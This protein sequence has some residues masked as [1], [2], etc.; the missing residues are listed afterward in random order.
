MKS[1]RYLSAALILLIL[2]TLGCGRE[3]EPE[4]EPKIDIPVRLAPVEVRTMSKPV[5]TYGRIASKR[6]IK[7]SFKTGGIIDEIL[8]DE[9][10]T[11]SRGQILARLD[12]AEIQA[13]VRQARSNFE[14]AERDAKRLQS[15]FDQEAAT[16]AQVQ[17]VET[18]LQ[19]ARAR[20]RAAEF[21]LQHSVI[22]A[23][24]R[25]RILRR[26]AEEDEVAAAGIPIFV[27]AS[28]ASDWVVRVGVSDADLVRLQL[29]DPAV[30]TFDAYPGEEFSARVAEIVE[31]ADP[32]TG[33]YEVELKIDSADKILV[34]GFVAE[35]EISPLRTR[36]FFVIP[37]DALTEAE[38]R[39]GRVFTVDRASLTARELTISIAF[40]FEDK[41]AV[42]EGLDGI[43]E[44]VTAG[45]PYL[46]PGA[47]VTILED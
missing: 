2:G 35:V 19:V 39:R 1:P 47:P 10:Q 16:L 24:A 34:S 37:M 21:N 31:S 17:N 40:F 41:M 23:P 14:K 25:G 18:V 7:L 4:A 33:T 8:A 46:G 3:G 28:L 36:D 44:V 38:G 20:L 11:V 22:E 30:V 42:E 13:Q 45:A 9:G 26:L 43:A 6:E 12:L 15:L 29:D 5:H 27:F 32:M